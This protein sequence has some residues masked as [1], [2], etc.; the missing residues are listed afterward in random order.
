MACAGVRSRSNDCVGPVPPGGEDASA[1]EQAVDIADAA[2]R[3][4]ARWWCNDGGVS[5][6]GRVGDAG[7][8]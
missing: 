5:D 4:R 7:G 8:A 1:P 6:G 3:R 2:R